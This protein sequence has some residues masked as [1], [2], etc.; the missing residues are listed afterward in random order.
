M[1]GDPEVQRHLEL[2]DFVADERAVEQEPE[3]R[4]DGIHAL[5]LRREEKE[6]AGGLAYPD[7]AAA[8]LRPRL[9]KGGEVLAQLVQAL[10]AYALEHLLLIADRR[11]AE[12][13][14]DLGALVQGRPPGEGGPPVWDAPNRVT[15]S[16]V[17]GETCEGE[18]FAEA[19]RTDTRLE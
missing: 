11:V 5:V 2:E 4:Q 9:E 16:R 1:E 12:T 7:D 17:R 19:I 14:R 10:V 13:C 8:F 3:G 18:G 6:A 15:G